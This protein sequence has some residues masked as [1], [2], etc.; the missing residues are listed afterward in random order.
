MGTANFSIMDIGASMVGTSTSEAVSGLLGSLSATWTWP[1][2]L[3]MAAR[4]PSLFHCE[5]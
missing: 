5:A 1:P 3:G 4:D 2:P